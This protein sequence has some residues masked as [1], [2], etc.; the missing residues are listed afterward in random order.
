MGEVL[1]SFTIHLASDGSSVYSDTNTE[2]DFQIHFSSPLQLDQGRWSVALTKMQYPRYIENLDAEC[3]FT[4]WNGYAGKTSYFPKW[5]CPNIPTLLTAINEYLKTVRFVSVHKKR[6][7]N[8]RRRKAREARETG[9]VM[10]NTADDYNFKPSIYTSV[11]IMSDMRRQ[12]QGPNSVINTSDLEDNAVLTINYDALFPNENKRNN[13]DLTKEFTDPNAKSIVEKDTI[14]AAIALFPLL[15]VFPIVQ[16][17]DIM[18]PDMY[19]SPMVTIDT[20]GRISFQSKCPDFDICFSDNL[21]RKLGITNERFSLERYARRRFFQAYL[22][23]MSK[24]NTFL[25]G[26]GLN[27][28]KLADS[29]HTERLSVPSSKSADPAE[30]FYL[31]INRVVNLLLKVN[32]EQVCTD[33]I[34][35]DHLADHH[36]FT[37]A[38]K[39]EEFISKNPNL[40]TGWVKET[41]WAKYF[42][43]KTFNNMLDIYRHISIDNPEPKF[44]EMGT[45]II[46]FMIKTLCDELPLMT[47]YTSTVPTQLNFPYDT[48]FIY[49]DII[50]TCIFNESQMP[51][52]QIMQSKTESSRDDVITWEP[53]NK[54][55][56][57]CVVGSIPKIR[58]YIA[59]TEGSLVPF[60][61]GPVVV[62]LLFRQ[63]AKP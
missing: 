2:S 48:L 35:A 56:K 51:L 61:L 16:L 43:M 47:P 24:N 17:A 59:S 8:A 44:R 50:E 15:S 10:S 45:F 62:Q 29:F 4:V 11:N 21:C 52:L 39:Y 9:V 57:P 12:F 22:L 25:F 23:H 1:N 7:D 37:T 31:Y 18:E 20:L 28:L 5:C 41:R 3:Y 33:F 36:D 54:I 30:S 13:K 32:S 55:F 34:L 60:M 14:A 42:P 19:D 46:Y 49:T 63:Q 40:L 38:E 53:R 6:M 58:I 27:Q 26:M